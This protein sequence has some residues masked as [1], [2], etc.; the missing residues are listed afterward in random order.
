MVNNLTEKQKETLE[1][2]E[3][4]I[5]THGVPPTLAELQILL[6]VSSNQA[7]L[8]HLDALEEKGVIERKRT[9]RGIRLIKKS[10]GEAQDNDFLSILTNLAEKRRQRIKIPHKVESPDAY[11]TDEESGKMLVGYYDNEQY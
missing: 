4:Y 9:A 11:S 3:S 5:T 10:E 8:N 7:V 1:V 2:I 6:N